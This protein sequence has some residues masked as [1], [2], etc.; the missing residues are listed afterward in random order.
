MLATKKGEVNFGRTK[1]FNAEA[2]AQAG[3]P[4]KLW[5]DR[6]HHGSLYI[7]HVADAA[8]PVKQP[9]LA[10][11]RMDPRYQQQYYQYYGGPVP[12]TSYA[13]QPVYQAA[14]RALPQV[15]RSLPQGPPPIPHASRP[16]ANSRPARYTRQESSDDDDL[17]QQI[18]ALKLKQASIPTFSYNEDPPLVQIDETP[19]IPVIEVKEPPSSGPSFS[20]SVAPPSPKA[21]KPSYVPKLIV[22]EPSDAPPPPRKPSSALPTTQSLANDMV[23]AGCQLPINGKILSAL[24]RRWHPDCFTCAYCRESLEHVA[25]FDYEGKPYCHFDYH[26][27]WLPVSLKDS[28]LKSTR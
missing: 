13:P 23:C 1:K 9:P 8:K 28:M 22:D 11:E 20:I 2:T 27:V 25:F 21:S 19:P 16:A 26:E 24:E 7:E 4:S 3:R 14:P 6:E 17:S 12:S 10:N 15:P 18:Q 5:R